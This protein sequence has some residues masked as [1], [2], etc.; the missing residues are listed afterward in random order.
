MPVEVTETIPL[1]LTGGVETLTY[2]TVTVDSV[3]FADSVDDTPWQAVVD[4]GNHFFVVPESLAESI[5]AAFDP[6]AVLEPEGELGPVY[7]VACDATP[8]ANVSIELGGRRFNIS[9]VDMI[10]QDFDGNCFSTLSPSAAEEGGIE[11]LFLGAYFLKNVVAVFDYGNLE[12]RFAD[13]LDGSSNHSSSTNVSSSGSP[14]TVEV[15]TQT[16]AASVVRRDRLVTVLVAGLVLAVA[17]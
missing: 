8:P 11:L 12:M 14:R 2:W 4:S 10:Y 5:N 7:T 17:V 13:R 16:D 1:E 6:P 15:Q 3:S 9:G